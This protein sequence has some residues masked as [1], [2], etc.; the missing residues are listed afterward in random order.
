MRPGRLAAV[1][2]LALACAAIPCAAV[3]Q[4]TSAPL[5]G[6]REGTITY[7]L[8]HKLHEVRG[9]SH[10]LEG[11][12]KVQ[13][14]RPTLVQVRVPLASFDSGNSNRDSHMR[15]ATHEAAHPYVEVKGT[16]P[17]LELPLAG[18]TELPLDARVELNGQVER[19]TIPVTLTQVGP[20]IRAKFSF[21]VSLDAH[22]VDRPELLLVKVDDKVTID[23]DVVF[24]AQK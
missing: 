1:A 23:G 3:A 21:P 13:P 16:L 11:L 7:T 14:G 8:V 6:I 12:A 17:P 24:E 20:A 5:Y 15:E 9:T 22:H 4:Q 2:T 18:K 10:K 19:Q